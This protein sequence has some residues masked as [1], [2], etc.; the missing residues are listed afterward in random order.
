[1]SDMILVEPFALNFGGAAPTYGVSRGTDGANLI[2]LDPREVFVDTGA[3]GTYTIDIDL[4]VATDWDTIALINITAAA[5]ATWSITGGATYTTT[6][7][8]A[9]TAMRLLSEDGVV[10]SSSPALFVSGATING[11]YVRITI[12]PGGA[13]TNSIGCLVIGRSWK[14]S[15]PREIGAGRQPLDTGSRSRLEGGGLAT[16]SG[17][18]TS[19]FKWVFGDL[20][21]TD[22]AKLW[23]IFR[24]RRTTE[25]LVLVEDPAVATAENVHYCTLVDLE[26]YER[27]V[28]TKSRWALTV[29]DWI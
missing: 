21:D 26:A 25:P 22:L 16:V 13:P 19:G 2:E 12:T 20:D 10:I 3:A 28:A 4:G 17:V 6:T 1:M 9:A 8:L 24:R 18:L 14:P 23:G 5:G 7:Y 27:R 29:E 15:M 11:R